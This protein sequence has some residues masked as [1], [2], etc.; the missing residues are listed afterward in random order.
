[1]N[2]ENHMKALI[3]D[4]E[5]ME[6]EQLRDVLDQKCHQVEQIEFLQNPVDAIMYLKK[7]PT[8]LL[9]LDIEM[10][11]MN[12]FEF[13]EIMGTENLPPVVFTTAH[14][15]YAVQA[16]KVHAIDYLLKPIDDVELVEAVQ[17]VS[18]SKSIDYRAQLNTLI[19]NPPEHFGDRVAL[20]EGQIHHFAKLND[21]VRIEGSG[22]YSVFHMSN[23][24]KITTSRSLSSYGSRL[25]NQGFVKSHQSHLINLS[26]ISSYSL[27]DGGELVL[28]NGDRIPVSARKKT[29]IKHTLG[30]S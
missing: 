11:A 28:E 21:I 24:K 3:V 25:E 20:T 13:I 17:K 4:D 2:N 7:H 10:P 5:F 6:G 8:D 18:N 16:F 27:S 15:K 29:H 14:S 1:M 30:L 22:S 12:G 19:N 9:F 26:F 23:G